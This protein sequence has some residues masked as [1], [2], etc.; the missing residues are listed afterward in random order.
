MID[1]NNSL[2]T[3]KKYLKSIVYMSKNWE[4]RKSFILSQKSKSNRNLYIKAL[5]SFNKHNGEKDKDLKKN[6]KLAKINSS[7]R[8]NFDYWEVYIEVR[9]VCEFFYEKYEMKPMKKALILLLLFETAIRISDIAA[10]R[11]NNFEFKDDNHFLKINTQKTNVPISAQL[12]IFCGKMIER[13]SELSGEDDVFIFCKKEG[14][15]KTTT[16]NI[17]KHI[18]SVTEK[19][20]K[21]FNILKTITPHDFRRLVLS[22]LANLNDISYAQSLSGHSNVNT[23]FI[24]LRGFK[25]TEFSKVH[26]SL[27]NNTT[28]VKKKEPTKIEI[29]KRINN[30]KKIL[31]LNN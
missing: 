11:Y 13:V 17:R 10:I 2:I 15:K 9:A 16:H 19:L 8:V 12:S 4:N 3:T 26:N 27:L 25:D 1:A 31:E 28:Y 5:K 22:K 14:F 23:L 7:K 18:R 20:P 24:Y 29:Q 21:E 6:F 30:M